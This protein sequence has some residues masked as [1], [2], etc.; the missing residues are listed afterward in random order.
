VPEFSLADGKVDIAVDDLVSV[1]VLDAVNHLQN[2][3]C[4][5]LESESS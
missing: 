4:D 5:C 2:D 1:Q 3:H